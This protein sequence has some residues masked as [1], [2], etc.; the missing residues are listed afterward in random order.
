M[1]DSDPLS[2]YRYHS[3]R[4]QG[5]G[6]P[7]E[8]FGHQCYALLGRDVRQPDQ[9]GV[10]LVVHVDQLTEV[11]IYRNQD[12]TRR[13]CQ[14]QQSSVPGIRAQGPRLHHIMS[15]S[16]EPLRQS[17]TCAPVYEEPHDAATET[18]ASVSPAI[19]VWA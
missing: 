9:P 1:R 16:L 17:A 10:R 4:F 6:M 15:A 12:P 19:T 8:D 3:F 7:L 13:C 14:L 11:G 5:V 18:E 2:T